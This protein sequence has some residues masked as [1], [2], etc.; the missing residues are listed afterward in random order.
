MYAAAIG[1][2]EH[3]RTTH[4]FLQPGVGSMGTNCTNDRPACLCAP[5]LFFLITPGAVIKRLV[6]AAFVEQLARLE[7]SSPTPHKTKGALKMATLDMLD[8]WL[9]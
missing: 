3:S 9:E 1:K 4:H 2:K 5:T 6:G 7:G 8:S